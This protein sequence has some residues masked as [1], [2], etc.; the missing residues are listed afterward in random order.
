MFQDPAEC[1]G[2][3][4]IVFQK[5]PAEILMYEAK[6]NLICCEPVND[7][8]GGKNDLVFKTALFLRQDIQGFIQDLC[9]FG[10]DDLVGISYLSSK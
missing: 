6:Q 9:G 4:T 7:M 8:I 2:E 5:S 10:N 3:F 1:L